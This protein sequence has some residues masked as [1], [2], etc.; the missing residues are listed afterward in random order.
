MIVLFYF[1]LQ[2]AGTHEVLSAAEACKVLH[3]SCRSRDLFDSMTRDVTSKGF[4]I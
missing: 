1:Y 3:L 2:Y 4:K